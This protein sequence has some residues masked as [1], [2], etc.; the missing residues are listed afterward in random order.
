[1]LYIKAQ[2]NPQIYEVNT[3]SSCNVCY[4]VFNCWTT[5]LRNMVY[6]PGES[7]PWHVGIYD[8]HCHPTDTLSS[9]Q[10][11]PTMKARVLV[12][13]A[14]R[15]EDQILVAGFADEFGLKQ[16][17]HREGDETEI[18]HCRVIPSFGWHPWFSHLLCDDLMSEG[19]HSHRSEKV[20]HYKRVITPSPEDSDFLQSLPDPYPLSQY[21]T[22]TR[23][24]LKRYPTALVGE[25]GIDRAFR[26][27]EHWL[28][29]DANVRQPDLSPDGREGRRL[30]PYRVNIDH[31]RKVLTAQLNLAGEM[32]RPVSV[33]G[34]SAHG[35][36]FETLHATWD[37]YEKKPL[38]K[39]SQKR[40]AG[41][42]SPCD[43]NNQNEVRPFPPRICLHSYSGPPDTLRRYLHQ[44]VPATIFFSFS[45]IINFSTS[46]KK[47]IDVVK[48]VPHTR[49]L[50][51]SD[52]HCAG[53]RMDELLETVIRSICHIKGW[54]LDEGTR[55]LAENWT[56]FVFGEE[57]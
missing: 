45:E 57:A 54:S 2:D 48:A 56:H 11:I 37:G 5:V 32:Q 14:T 34:V 33:H 22:K 18:P 23:E 36:L 35:L 43:P 40:R 13:M 7:F 55:Q 28:P 4:Y 29:D 38:S 1:M 19:G 51:E 44:S 16:T 12:I 31:Q 25:I 6:H 42:N 53:A 10:E 21:I 3:G 47:A 52:L 50:I 8:A 27:P 17:L 20:D 39:R 9:R 15:P 30:S 49:L 46:S 24:Y 41:V 26:I